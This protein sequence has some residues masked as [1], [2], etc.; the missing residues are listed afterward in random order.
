MSFW[1]FASPAT[2]III[3]LN[4]MLNCLLFNRLQLCRV[5]LWHLW[6]YPRSLDLVTVNTSRFISRLSLSILLLTWLLRQHLTTVSVRYWLSF[7]IYFF[8]LIA[9]IRFVIRTIRL[10]LLLFYRSLL[11]RLVRVLLFIRDGNSIFRW[12]IP[13][14]WISVWLYEYWWSDIYGF[15]GLLYLMV[16]MV[17]LIIIILVYLIWRIS[18]D[19]PIRSNI[20]WRIDKYLTA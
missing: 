11:S 15:D 2:P 16:L 6:T 5:D 20:F 9:F 8:L 18:M 13:L 14:T 7:Q 17:C 4:I 1:F 19:L 12:W 10:R 3:I